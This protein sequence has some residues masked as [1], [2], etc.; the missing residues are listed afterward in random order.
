MIKG[1][2]LRNYQ[3]ETTPHDAIQL[4]LSFPGTYFQR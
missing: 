1:T 4:A 2:H 3:S